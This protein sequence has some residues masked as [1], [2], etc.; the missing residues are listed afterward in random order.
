MSD[1]KF[2][3]MKISIE[4]IE[5]LQSETEGSGLEITVS[6]EPAVLER[7]DALVAKLSES[8]PT[9]FK[10]ISSEI[11]IEGLRLLEEKYL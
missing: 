3:T 9:H 8:T 4:D 11:F 10:S 2:Q 6:V 1:D 7:V 5:K